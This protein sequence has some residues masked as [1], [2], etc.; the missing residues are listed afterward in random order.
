MKFTIKVNNL[1]KNQVGGSKI[2]N[3]SQLF[4]NHV[5]KELINKNINFV[6]YNKVDG[7][8][9]LSRNLYY[10]EEWAADRA[11]HETK[12]QDGGVYELI[13]TKKFLER[14]KE[15]DR[16]IEVTLVETLQDNWSNDDQTY[17]VYKGIYNP[18]T[19]FIINEIDPSKK[20][21]KDAFT[22]E[23]D[24]DKWDRL[25]FVG[26]EKDFKIISAKKEYVKIVEVTDTNES[27][28][29]IKLKMGQR[30]KVFFYNKIK[31]I[32]KWIYNTDFVKSDE[33]YEIFN[34]VSV[35][36]L[37]QEIQNNRPDLIKKIKK[38]HEHDKRASSA[39][40]ICE[41]VTITYTYNRKPEL[42][43]Y[44]YDKELKPTVVSVTVN[45]PA[46]ESDS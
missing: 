12:L 23:G 26:S 46:H 44:D 17:T 15:T 16:V 1:F 25:E 4:Y 6:V 22:I 27:V 20:H 28:P 32:I 29:Y 5:E 24:K 36:T 13:D 18:P 10:V 38:H 9:Y 19:K 37:L 31:D 21:L 30:E 34:S 41:Q 45:R 8:K 42:R 35:E 14:I 11:F 7:S 2:T 39:I 33:Y 40:Y 3:S 43:E